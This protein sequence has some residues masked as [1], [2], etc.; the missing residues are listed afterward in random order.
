MKVILSPE[1]IERL[2]AQIAYLDD[3]EA[4]A[5]ADRLSVRV[6]SFL[7]N[8]LAHFPRAGRRLERGD[9]WEMWIPGTRLVLWYR[10]EEERILIAT[11]W[12]AAQDRTIGRS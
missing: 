8:H 7:S 11:V 4:S 12:H 10:I 5:A 2:Q 9:L 3:V 6:T 1:A